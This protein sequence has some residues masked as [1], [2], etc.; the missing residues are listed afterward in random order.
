M[1]MEEVE[2]EDEMRWKAKPKSKFNLLEEVDDVGAS[3]IEE[4][5]GEAEMFWLNEGRIFVRDPEERRDDIGEAFEKEVHSTM[6]KEKDEK[7]D[8]EPDRTPSPVPASPFADETIR[9]YKKQK[10][11]AGRSA[12]GTSVLSMKERVGDRNGALID[13]RLDTCTDRTLISEE[14]YNKI[15]NAPPIQQGIPVKLL[16]LM[17]EETGI[18]GFTTIPL[19]I[20]LEEGPELEMEAEAYVVPGMCYIHVGKGRK[21]GRPERRKGRKDG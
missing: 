20:K 11:K 1:R 16:Q 12:M 18:E 5:R 6:R 13:I 21:D 14:F 19:Y 3:E 8:A 7:L 2:D 15:K 4:G 17:Q 10:A 9:L